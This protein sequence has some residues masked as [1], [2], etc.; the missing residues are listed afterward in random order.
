MKQLPLL[1]GD[2]P[3]EKPT[4]RPILLKMYWQNPQEPPLK[5]WDLA[6]KINLVKAIPQILSQVVWKVPGHKLLLNGVTISLITCSDLNGNV[7]KDLVGRFNGN[8]K[9]VQVKACCL[10]HWISTKRTELLC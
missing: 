3:S 5:K 9:T 8:L 10:M 7:I 1:Q 2:T 4:A 6:G